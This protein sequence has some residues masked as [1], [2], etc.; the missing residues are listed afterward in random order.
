MEEFKPTLEIKGTKDYSIFKRLP[1]NRLKTKA[2]VQELINSFEELPDALRQ[3]RAIIVDEDLK[4]IDGQHS[5]EAAEVRGDVA[6][7]VVVPGMK[8][9]QT[10]RMNSTQKGWTIGDFVESYADEIPDYRQLMDIHERYS[11]PYTRLTAILNNPTSATGGSHSSKT[12][13]EGE[14]RL[15]SVK[16][17]LAR[18]ER[19]EDYSAFTNKWRSDSLALAVTKMMHNEGYDHARMMNQLQGKKLDNRGSWVD[20]LRDLEILYN[21][22]PGSRYVKF[23]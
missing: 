9:P 1:G 6:W 5:L 16:E 20:Y 4:V 3:A 13:K 21:K 18:L 23:L 14:W 10:R 8:L 7:Y 15:K 2:H 22:A 19:L 12:I 11:L 17:G